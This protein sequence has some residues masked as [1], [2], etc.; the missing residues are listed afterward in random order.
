MYTIY[1]I[2]IILAGLCLSCPQREGGNETTTSPQIGL[3]TFRGLSELDELLIF[4]FVIP[5]YD[6]ERSHLIYYS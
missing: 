5:Q 6:I 4:K 3:E 2:L 1:P